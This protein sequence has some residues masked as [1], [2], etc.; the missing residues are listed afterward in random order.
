VCSC[1]VPYVDVIVVLLFMVCVWYCFTRNVVLCDAGRDDGRVASSL[2]AQ[3]REAH[4]RTS[5]VEHE[6]AEMRASLTACKVDELETE[7]VQ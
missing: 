1:H 5:T 3:V 4:A 2:K 7:A 6:W